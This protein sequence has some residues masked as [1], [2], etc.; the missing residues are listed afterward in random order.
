MLEDDLKAKNAEMEQM[1]SSW[2][3][4]LQAAL[5]EQK[6]KQAWLQQRADDAVERA[7]QAELRVSNLEKAQE[8]D[9]ALQKQAA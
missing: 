5:L 6:E 3:Q 7:K 8:K 1:R 2:D 4:Q 9:Q